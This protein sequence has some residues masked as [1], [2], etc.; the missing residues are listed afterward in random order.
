MNDAHFSNELAL[1]GENIVFVGGG[2]MATALI[3]GLLATKDQQKLDV[4][5]GVIETNAEKLDFFRQKGVKAAL[6]TDAKTL[7][8]DATTVV[9]AVKP[10]VMGE[11]CAGI[12]A[13]LQDKLVISVAAGLSLRSLYQTT[14]S[15]RLVRA[16]PNLPASVGLGATG[17]FAEDLSEADVLVAQS[18][19]QASGS[20][21][22]VQKEDDLHAV[23]AV[24]GSAP[25]YFFYILEAMTAKACQ[26]G[27]P[28]DVAKA[29]ATQAMAGAAKMAQ[30]D[31][32]AVLR[33]KVT[34]KGGTTHAAICRLQ[35]DGVD[36]KI[37]DAMQACFDRSVELG[38]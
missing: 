18:A 37:A 29:L 20:A 33:S 36:Q 4:R 23:T 11:V 16:M 5:L 8:A 32:P 7:L 21:F 22:W 27:L 14:E 9:L 2:N 19:M 6:Y 10:Q 24:A 12:R 13:F 28:K 35:A 26:M 30:S 38:G 34:S 25:A 3:D 1:Q 15:K 31:D 17:L